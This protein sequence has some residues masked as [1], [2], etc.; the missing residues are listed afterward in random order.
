MNKQTTPLIALM[1]L[2]AGL[3][4]VSTARGAG[5]IVLGPAKIVFEAEDGKV[6]EPFVVIEHDGASGGKVV[7]LKD[8]INKKMGKAP[9][10]ELFKGTIEYSF[11]VDKEAEYVLWIRA[12]WKDGCGNSVYVS[13]D[14]PIK[15]KKDTPYIED[16]TF[17]MHNHWVR[18]N[19]RRFH[20]TKGKH[21]LYVR[22]REDGVWLDMFALVEYEKDIDADEQYVPQGPEPPTS[23]IIK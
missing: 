17:Q 3:V 12:I 16:N 7:F 19:S 20:L 1:L 5:I 13:I 22:N 2:L 6:T 18:L 8:G 9:G 14:E 21:V 10:E 15:S 11:N 4:Y 23:H